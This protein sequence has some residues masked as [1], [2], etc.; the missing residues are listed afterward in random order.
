MRKC[1]LIFLALPLSLGCA[2]LP[3]R[4]ARVDLEGI[5]YEKAWQATLE[6]IRERFPLSETSKEKGLIATNYRVRRGEEDLAR[7]ARLPSGIL[8][9]PESLYTHRWK[10]D[11][12][13]TSRDHTVRVAIRVMKERL[14]APFAFEASPRMFDQPN[15]AQQRAA[16]PAYGG[17]PYGGGL[18][19]T[20]VGRDRSM[21]RELLAAIRRR[22]KLE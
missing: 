10:A 11:A 8:K 6:V 17:D 20:E 21:E 3:A 22:L 14:E 4:R 19:W 2:A 15:F 5:S 7:L 12:R 9:G 1:L 18:L 16:A 13:V